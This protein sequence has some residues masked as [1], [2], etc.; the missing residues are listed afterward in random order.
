MA[1]EHHDGLF[2][3]AEVVVVDT[4]VWEKTQKMTVKTFLIFFITECNACFNSSFT[5]KMFYEVQC[6]F[7]LILHPNQ[8]LG[9]GLEEVV[10]SQVNLPAHPKAR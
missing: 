9:G 5:P 3:V 7:Q 2:S 6:M 1:F 10:A 4:V 8:E